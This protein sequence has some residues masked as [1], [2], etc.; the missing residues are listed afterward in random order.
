MSLTVGSLYTGS[1]RYARSMSSVRAWE[2]VAASLGF[3]AI[4][5]IIRN[6]AHPSGWWWIGLEVLALAVFVLGATFWLVAVIKAR[7][8]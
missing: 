6:E 5:A 4:L 1:P 8:R 3:A 7:R 2:I